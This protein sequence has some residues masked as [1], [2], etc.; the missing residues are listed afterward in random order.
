M[1]KYFLTKIIPN[2]KYICIFIKN[3]HIFKKVLLF[4]LK[5][6]KMY[7]GREIYP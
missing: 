7:T 4:L 3:E 6:D 1:V 2:K 5:F